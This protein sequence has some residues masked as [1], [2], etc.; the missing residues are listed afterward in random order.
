MAVKGWAGNWKIF[1]EIEAGREYLR[2]TKLIVNRKRKFVRK[3]RK[4]SSK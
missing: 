1:Y 3:G 4:N 2:S